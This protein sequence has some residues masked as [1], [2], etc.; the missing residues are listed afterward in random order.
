MIND[1][2]NIAVPTPG[3]F[4]KEELEAREWTQ[5]DL[6]YV[7]G[8]SPQ[9]LHAILAGKRGISSDMAKALGKAFDVSAAFFTNLQAAYD[10]SV[11]TDPDPSIEHRARLQDHFPVREMIKRGW[12]DDGLDSSL[13]EEQMMRF[14]R[15]KDYE[16]I[17]YLQHAAKKTSAYEDR[18]IPPV[19]L[20]WLFRVYQIAGCLEVPRYSQAK[21]QNALSDLHALMSEPEEIRQVPRI[22]NECGIRLV[23][24]EALPQAKIDGVCCWLD[25]HSPVI[26]M[27]LRFDRIDNFWFVLR[28]EIEHVLNKDGQGEGREILDDLETLEDDASIP[29]EEQRANLAAQEFSVPRDKLV[30]FIVRKHPYFAE[31]DI[32][33]FARVLG[34]HIGIVIGQIHSYTR[35]FKLLRKHLVKVRQFVITGGIVDGW[36]E[37]FPISL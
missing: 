28:H 25:K 24:V 18:K 34:V 22:L 17:P 27:S 11:A 4:I 31:Q 16:S 23:F 33:G 12:I 3:E 35:N 6:A 19:Q 2:I 26:G 15:V 21:L 10:L 13:L 8:I 9:N 5:G 20:A 1:N 32:A 36:G 14:F 29:E 37:V 7:L 30:G